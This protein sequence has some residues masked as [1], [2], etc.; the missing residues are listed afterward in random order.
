[1]HVIP[2]LTQL[3]LYPLRFQYKMDIMMGRFFIIMLGVVQAISVLGQ[4][5]EDFAPLHEQ[6]LTIKEAGHLKAQEKYQIAALYLNH[7]VTLSHLDTA[8]YYIYKAYQY[9]RKADKKEQKGLAKMGITEKAI[10]ALK[11]EIEDVYVDEVFKVNTL[12]AFDTLL[13]RFKRLNP[14]VHEKVLKARHELAY[15][16]IIAID[17]FA[18]FKQKYLANAA[19]FGSDAPIYKRQ[20]DQM[21]IDR[22]FEKYDSTNLLHVL[23][24][25]R[26]FPNLGARMDTLLSKGLE[27][28]PYIELVEN[29]LRPYA[30]RAFP[31]TVEKIYDYYALSG[32]AKDLELFGMKYPE[33]TTNERFNWDLDV[34]RQGEYKFTSGFKD[35]LEKY[36]MTNPE[37]YRSFIAVQKLLEKQ[38]EDEDWWGAQQTLA[39]VLPQLQGKSTQWGLN[40]QEILRDTTEEYLAFP[41][42]TTFINTTLEEYAPVMSFDGKQL[43][44]C[45]R[46]IGKENVFVTE[47]NAL[48]QW[49]KPI[50]IMAI[51]K[52]EQNEAPI[53][54]S[55]DGS[56]MLIFEE[57]IV[58]STQRTKTGWSALSP[59]LPRELQS[60]WQGVTTI[61]SDQ[62]VAIF[63][64]RRADRVGLPKEENIDLYVSIKDETGQWGF[65]EN[66]GI[67]INTPFEERSPFLHPDMRTLYFSSNGHGGLGDLDV[68]KV[69]RLGDGW[70]EWSE[71]VNLGKTI[72]TPQKDWGYR[73]STDG[74]YAY[75][76]MELES[77][78]DEIFQVELPDFAR[79]ET[80]YTIKG[81]LTDLSGRPF[82]G[83]LEVFNLEDG[84]IVNNIQPNPSTG[85]YFVT[86]PKGKWYG[87]RA[88]APGYFPISGHLDTRTTEQ[89]N[90]ERSIVVPKTDDLTDT[91]HIKLNN[92]FFDHDQAEI[93]KESFADLDRLAAFVK[94]YDQTIEIAGHTDNTGGTDYNLDLSAKRA[95]AVKAYLINQG[96]EASQIQ[97]KGYGENDPVAS[98]ED[99]QGQALNRRVEVRFPKKEVLSH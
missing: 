29:F 92:L 66:L 98:N 24:F 37:G 96:C 86:L 64:A 68:F 59:L 61:S 1:M 28:K 93:K 88:K 35:H 84:G 77:V 58:K 67:N 22:F 16:D 21:L 91:T 32:V 23:Y 47:K 94:D 51:N 95:E 42:D 55:V 18:D 3:F 57:G 49:S 9:W 87:Y 72:N 62:Q 7:H 53:A 63:A 48:G 99:E 40:L 75:F 36:I 2:F 56:S 14:V 76:S 90:L 65:P 82:E 6:T 73:I 52:P 69:T 4:T 70:L 81:K 79:P 71:P 17:S 60:T 34:A 8:D 45:R 78:Q 33:F 26:D 44:F 12:S 54:I 31:L 27:E 39:S 5:T 46:G 85:E 43:Y 80:V 41:I 20:L 15:N 30:K 38:L 13:V 89:T 74:Q 10:K 97:A 11:G 19:S 25:M 50:P 83:S